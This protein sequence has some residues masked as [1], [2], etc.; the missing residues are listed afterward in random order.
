MDWYYAKDDQQV[1]PIDQAQFDALLSEGAINL[2]TLVW[3]QDMGDWQPYGEVAT[4]APTTST[5]TA[6]AVAGTASCA[7]CGRSFP[8]DEMISYS[9]SYVCA[10]CKPIF[11]QR[12]REGVPLDQ[13]FEYGGFWIR[14]GA[15]IID[16]IVLSAIQL[17]ML[18]LLGLSMG[19]SSEQS[20]TV[21]SVLISN[22]LSVGLQVA[23]TVFFLG[24]FAATPGKMVCGLK[25][26]RPT[27]ERITYLRALGRWFAEILSSLI[28]L[29]GYI[30]AAFD[31][32]KRTLHDR[33]CDTRVVRSR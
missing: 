12:V 4:Q 29:I 26:V 20:A 32:E 27:G 14:V 7:E 5:A 22:L 19:S 1:G 10:E 11:F 3:H 28:F 23:Y 21:V 18:L 24:K 15:K 2:S 13:G 17:P 33:I 6:T 25:V 30:M 8:V 16:G 9:G 31:D